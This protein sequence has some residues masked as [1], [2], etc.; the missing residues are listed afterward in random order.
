MCEYVS[1]DVE[2]EWKHF[3][4]TAAGDLAKYPSG[5]ME[6]YLFEILIPMLSQFYY[7]VSEQHG[8]KLI[9]MSGF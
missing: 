9:S 3:F 7:H 8:H 2:T 1:P 6:T 4:E 5:D